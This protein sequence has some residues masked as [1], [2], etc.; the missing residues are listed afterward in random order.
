[1]RFFCGLV[2]GAT[3]RKLTGFFQIFSF[4]TIFDIYFFIFGFF[5]MDFLDFFYVLDFLD[6]FRFLKIYYELFGLFFKLLRLLLKVTKVTT[7][8]QKWTKIGQKIR[9][10][11]SL[12]NFFFF[13]LT[14]WWSFSVKGLLS[15]VP[16]PPSLDF[17]LAL[18]NKQIGTLL[19]S[20]LEIK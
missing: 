7:G 1:M 8:H 15:K 2:R 10:T 3:D 12:F 6:F 13:L 19:M 16:S 4:S 14:N 5:F 18:V 9:P 20:R 11:S 17:S